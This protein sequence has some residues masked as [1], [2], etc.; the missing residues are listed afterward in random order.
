MHGNRCKFPL[1]YVLSC[2]KHG[3]IAELTPD[4]GEHE[5]CCV[6]MQQLVVCPVCGWGILYRLQIP[7]PLTPISVTTPSP[8]PGSFI[9]AH[10]HKRRN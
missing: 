7:E 10:P 8:N 2:K 6:D 4:Q 3:L 1:S 5:V 9:Y